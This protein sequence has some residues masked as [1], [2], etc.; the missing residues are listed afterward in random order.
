MCST[1]ALVSKNGAA[2]PAAKSGKYR[3]DTTLVMADLAV[4]HSEHGL[5]TIAT[6]AQNL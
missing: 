6:I 1:G 5:S 2:A 4:A 3:T